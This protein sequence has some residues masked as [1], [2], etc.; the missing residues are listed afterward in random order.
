MTVELY[1]VGLILKPKGLKGE[2]KVL[3]VTDF[4]ESFLDRKVFYTGR[5]GEQAVRRTVLHAVMRKGFAY[6]LFSG[7]DSREKAEA[8]SGSMVYVD[9]DALIPLP[10]DRAYLH[11]IRG[12]KVVDDSGVEMGVVHDVLQMPAHEV[13]EIKCGNR[14]IL[15]P[16]IEEFVEEI[17]IAEGYMVLKRF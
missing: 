10:P 14:V 15:V 2:V 6:L 12:L 3:P 8:L 16:A 11:E 13:Y 7:V 4:P 1:Q 5:D 17:A 9:R